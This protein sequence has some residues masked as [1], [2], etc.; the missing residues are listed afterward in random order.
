MLCPIPAPPQ[1][2]IFDLDGTLA[3][4]EAAWSRAKTEVADSVGLQITADRVDA[5]MG[6]S[7]MDFLRGEL[8]DQAADHVVLAQ[9]VGRLARVYLPQITQPMPGAVDLVRRLQ[10]VGVPMAVCSSSGPD[11]IDNAL[12]RLGISDAFEIKVSGFVLPRGKPDPMPYREALRQLSCGPAAALAFEDSP[13]GVRSAT[14]AGIATIGLGE[15]LGDMAVACAHL[16]PDLSHAW[17]VIGLDH[18]D[19]ALAGRG[20]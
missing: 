11:L 3:D 16:I 18:A 8:P 6:R 15:H 17:A 13:T 20:S 12:D 1:A 10:A 14:G 5:Y 7:V 19:R 9:E 2:I 4:T